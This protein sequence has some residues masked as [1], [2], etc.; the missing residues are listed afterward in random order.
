MVEDRAIPILTCE[1]VLLA[2]AQ[3]EQIQKSATA[4]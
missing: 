4:C 3:N 2:I 1:C